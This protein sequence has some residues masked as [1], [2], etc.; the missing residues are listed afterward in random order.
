[1]KINDNDINN[2][3]H[4]KSFKLMDEFKEVMQLVKQAQ[5]KLSS[6]EKSL[7]IYRQELLSC[8]EDKDEFEN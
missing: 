4:T 3:L 6:F 2:L 5:E 8:V 7:V 1:M